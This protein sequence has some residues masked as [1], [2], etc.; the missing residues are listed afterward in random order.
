VCFTSALR[1]SARKKTDRELAGGTGG[2][3]E[4]REEGL[5]PGACE[6]LGEKGPADAGVDENEAADCCKI[7]A[8]GQSGI[9]DSAPCASVSTLVAAHVPFEVGEPGSKRVQLR[10]PGPVYSAV[11]HHHKPIPSIRYQPLRQRARA[12]GF[13]LVYP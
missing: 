8:E 13:V 5:G 7:K 11:A 1:V 4:E 3:M 12:S 10:P 2:R 9:Q 6:V